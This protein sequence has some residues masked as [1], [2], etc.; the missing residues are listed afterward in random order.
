VA[1]HIA[2]HQAEVPD[3]GDGVAACGSAV[4]RAMTEFATTYQ[5]WIMGRDAQADMQEVIA[6]AVRAG[7]AASSFSPPSSDILPPGHQ[8]GCAFVNATL[9]LMGSPCLALAAGNH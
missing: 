6:A 4:T 7:A 2:R 9:H 1:G 3:V 5:G 8:E